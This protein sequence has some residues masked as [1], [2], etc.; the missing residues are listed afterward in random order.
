MRKRRVEDLLAIG[1]SVGGVGVAE[2]ELVAPLCHEAARVGRGA[3]HL[4]A[5]VPL[6]AALLFCLSCQSVGYSSLPPG[7]IH[8]QDVEAHPT[9]FVVTG[10]LVDKLEERVY[11][12]QQQI[13]LNER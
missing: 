13:L 5:L 10:L 7:V 1:V 4:E 12:K 3:D 11:L 6:S 9:F 2:D 8:R